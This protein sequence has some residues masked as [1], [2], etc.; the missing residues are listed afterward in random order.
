MVAQ[1]DVTVSAQRDADLAGIDQPDGSGDQSPACATC[2]F[3]FDG[4][5]DL[6]NGLKAIY[7]LDWQYDSNSGTA[8]AGRDQWLGVSGNF[9]EVKVGTMSTATSLKA[10]RPTRFIVRRCP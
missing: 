3:G 7:R 8:P 2:S 6:G 10:R 1:A 9:G 5:E 4:S